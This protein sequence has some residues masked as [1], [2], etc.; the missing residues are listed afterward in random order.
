[1]ENDIRCGKWNVKSLSR[2]QS[3]KTVARRLAKYK[4]DLV[5]VQEARVIKGGGQ[6]T[7]DCTF[8]YGN[9]NANLY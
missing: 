4:L 6:P 2:A 1:M 8:S 3:L 9:R 7:D 5:A